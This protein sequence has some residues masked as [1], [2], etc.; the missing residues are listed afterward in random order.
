MQHNDQ[1]CIVCW[2]NLY[3]VRC[4]CKNSIFQSE[5]SWFKSYNW[6]RSFL[7]SFLINIYFLAKNR[8]LCIIW[9]LNNQQCT[10]WDLH[11]KCEYTSKLLYWLGDTFCNRTW[12]IKYICKIYLYKYKKI[13]CM[14]TIKYQGYFLMAW[15]WRSIWKGSICLEYHGVF[16]GGCG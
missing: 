2:D 16:L 9:C 14:N 15:Y 1:A 12:K 4:D 13:E 10:I 8:L 6:E 11:W 5:D 7:S 3:F